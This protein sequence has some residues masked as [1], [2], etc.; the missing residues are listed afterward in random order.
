MSTF[1]STILLCQVSGRSRRGPSN[2]PSIGVLPVSAVKDVL[3]RGQP[4]VDVMLPNGATLGDLA[5]Y[6]TRRYL[7]VLRC[8]SDAR[9]V[10][11]DTLRYT[12]NSACRL[13][14]RTACVVV[15]LPFYLRDISTHV[16]SVQACD[17]LRLLES[18]SCA[19]LLFSHPF[20]IGVEAC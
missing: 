3:I 17:Q 19:S 11:L 9:S 12:V 7:L 18:L 2:R 16:S 5:L 13:S 4:F 14:S 10:S 15:A 1:T 8:S 20:S 6:V